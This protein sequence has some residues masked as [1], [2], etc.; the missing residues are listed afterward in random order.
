MTDRLCIS[1]F[2]V[3]YVLV[4]K[5]KLVCK[6]IEGIMC[7]KSYMVALETFK[8]YSGGK[9]SRGKARIRYTF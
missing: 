8:F 1:C 6:F 5:D 3:M 9:A 4:C 7:L 2:V